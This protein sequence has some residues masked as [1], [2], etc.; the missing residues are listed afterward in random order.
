MGFLVKK[1]SLG[2]KF[3][4]ASGELLL[5]LLSH[6]MITILIEVGALLH[7]ERGTVLAFPRPGDWLSSEQK[8]GLTLS[9]N[10]VRPGLSAN[11]S[12]D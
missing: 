2:R 9:K 8:I 7:G 10:S 11:P 3:T 4:A 12:R 5:S 6:S 1:T